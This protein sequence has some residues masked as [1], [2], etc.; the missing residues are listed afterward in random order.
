[1]FN[2]ACLSLS[3][4]IA[5]V[6]CNWATRAWL[7]NS[8]VGLLVLAT[9]VLYTC[10]TFMVAAVLCLVERKPVF[11]LWQN[12]FFWS[13]PYY[14]VGAAASGLMAATCRSAGWQFS[15]LVLPMTGLVYLTYRLHVSHFESA[16]WG[17]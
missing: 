16:L 1:L 9:F 10:N 17:S 14:M 13:F 4:A 3:T 7:S 2:G 15:L 6:V 12:C 5:Y 8:L 11:S